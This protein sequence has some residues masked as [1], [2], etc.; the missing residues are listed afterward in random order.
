MS[1]PG[2]RRGR[3]HD[4]EGARQTILDAAEEVFAEKG[5]EGASL[6]EIAQRAGYTRGAIYKH[7]S[8]K[9]V[10]ARALA[11]LGEHGHEARQPVAGRKRSME[12]EARVFAATPRAAKDMVGGGR[13]VELLGDGAHLERDL[14]RGLVHLVAARG[15]GELVDL[16]VA[17]DALE[18]DGDSAEGGGGFGNG[19]ARIVDGGAGGGEFTSVLVG[20]AGDGTE[21]EETQ[22]LGIRVGGL[23]DAPVDLVGAEECGL[24]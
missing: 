10:R 15:L 20:V 8:S 23:D 2:S 6:E 21:G 1:E 3:A 5:F 14:D 22:H 4:A 18:G 19:V 24:S 17:D 7:F 13:D 12:R 9:A 11:I 16:G